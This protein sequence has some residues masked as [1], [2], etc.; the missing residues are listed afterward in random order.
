METL[1]IIPLKNQ[2]FVLEL[3]RDSKLFIFQKVKAIYFIFFLQLAPLYSEEP[4]QPFFT[5]S[6]VESH[7]SDGAT[8]A[9]FNFTLKNTTD[10]PIRIKNVEVSC[11]CTGVKS[12]PEAFING[13]NIPTGKSIQ[14]QASINIGSRKGKWAE[15][16]RVILEHQNGATTTEVLTAKIS[17]PVLIQLLPTTQK[18]IIGEDL[19]E[20]TI[21]VA[22]QE[23][24][25]IIPTKIEQQHNDYL[26][27]LHEV[28]PGV[29]YE[30]KLTPKSTQK[31]LRSCHTNQVN[32][33]ISKNH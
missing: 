18:W 22:I 26:Y 20:K 14:L 7:V 25:G 21:K 4:L 10:S 13:K 15:Q 1:N 6:V 3:I 19:T 32:Q 2:A 5:N 27:E 33:P 29:L 12:S 11:T 16:V 31:F 30:I 24:S 23:G 8:T 28:E 9:E 17:V